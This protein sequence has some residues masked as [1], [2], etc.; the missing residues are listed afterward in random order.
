[1][2]LKQE[3][4]HGDQGGYLF[5][6]MPNVPIISGSKEDIAIRRYIKF[7]GNF[8][9]YGNPTPN[10]EDFGLIW[11]P[12]TIESL[13]YLDFDEELSLKINPDYKRVT[14]WRAIYKLNENTKDFIP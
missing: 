11:K 6:P 10:Q 8:V 14:F 3:A 2:G 7:W 5:L 13:H 9:K 12:V 1:M 4:T